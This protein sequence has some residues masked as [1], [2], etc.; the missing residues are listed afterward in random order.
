VIKKALL[1]SLLA[2]ALPVDAGEPLTMGLTPSVAFEP[3]H[4]RIRTVIE[5]HDEN[6]EL[7]IIAQSADF[8]RSSVIQLE[9]ANAP[10]VNL[11]EFRNLPTGPTR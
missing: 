1:L 7:Q 11:F 10:R 3:A 4:L 6:R 5:A 9:G 2:V 8:Y